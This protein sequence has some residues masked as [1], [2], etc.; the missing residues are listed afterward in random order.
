MINKGAME[1]RPHSNELIFK[2]MP[3]PQ[4]HHRTRQTALLTLLVLCLVFPPA[5]SSAPPQLDVYLCWVPLSLL[6]LF[7]SKWVSLAQVHASGNRQQDNQD[8]LSWRAGEIQPLLLV[9][10]SLSALPSSLAMLVPFSFFHLLVGFI[11]LSLTANILSI[12][13]SYSR[14]CLKIP[15]HVFR[16]T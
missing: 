9:F 11:L 4:K 7:L 8:K 6:L 5:L 16:H 12:Y 15:S 14:G 13:V 3:L 1:H 10:L 2:K